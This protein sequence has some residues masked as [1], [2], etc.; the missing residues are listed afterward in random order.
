MGKKIL[1]GL[2]IFA[3]VIISI[4]IIF[5]I[6]AKINSGDIAKPD[7]SNLYPSSQILSKEDNAFDDF[8]KASDGVVFSNDQSQSIADLANNKNWDNSLAKQ[9]VKDNSAA[10]VALKQGSLKK[11]YQD[12]ILQN[13][14]NKFN[15]ET[16]LSPL[17]NVRKLAQISV[18]E[19][20]LFFEQGKKREAF[21][22]TLKTIQLG[23]MLEDSPRGN[24]LSYLV[25]MSIKEVAITN[26]QSMI[27]NNN[28]TVGEL[29]DYTSKI[30]KFKNNRTGLQESF[31]MEYVMIKNSKEQTI[32]PCISSGQ[33]SEFLPPVVA[34]SKV[35]LKST[36]YYKPNKTHKL[37]IERYKKFVDNA[38]KNC[39]EIISSSPKEEE[40]SVVK[41]LFT[42]NA[43]GKILDSIIGV[44]IEGV[45]MK[46][47]EEEF[48]VIKT[49]ISLASQAYKI[50]N[51]NYPNS[52]S[53][54]YPNYL[55]QVY[56]QFNGEDI[57]Y[58]AKTGEASINKNLYF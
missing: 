52:L 49:Q 47:C 29:R 40:I 19:S 14:L 30:E 32:D 17:S 36:F 28:L 2:G 46:R 21:D 51:G 39:N 24:L 1:W 16:V 56:E 37:F 27:S 9:I 42:E 43:V 3:L 22:N 12:P 58:D 8:K 34:D 38:I 15:S 4:V 7:D 50:D 48:S 35:L 53:Q 26:L 5:L 25:G 57:I 41:A 11:G 44:S 31:K 23:Q 33:A 20:R 45:N 13:D 54:L 6:Y 18:I 55:N 10:L